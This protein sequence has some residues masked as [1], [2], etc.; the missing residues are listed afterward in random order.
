MTYRITVPEL[1]QELDRWLEHL[2]RGDSV[3]LATPAHLLT[4]TAQTGSPPAKSAVPAASAPPGGYW[5][6]HRPAVR[7]AS[8]QSNAELI[9]ELRG[10]G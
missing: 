6:R 4:L 10:E 2:A 9:A 1:R 8:A 3:Q 7:L 5:K